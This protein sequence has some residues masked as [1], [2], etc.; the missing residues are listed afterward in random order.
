[1]IRMAQQK[2][3]LNK[4]VELNEVKTGPMKTLKYQ[5]LATT[6]KE[7]FRSIKPAP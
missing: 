5:P 1:M 7:K 3:I 6:F 2:P 4:M